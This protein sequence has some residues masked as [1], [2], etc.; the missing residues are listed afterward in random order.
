MQGNTPYRNF[1][2]GEG[3]GIVHPGSTS[4]TNSKA[5][6]QNGLNAKPFGPD[7]VMVAPERITG[8]SQAKV[9]DVGLQAKWLH[10]LQPVFSPCCV[11]LLC[12]GR[13]HD[14]DA[15]DIGRTDVLRS[16][17]IARHAKMKLKVQATDSSPKPRTFPL[18]APSSAIKALSQRSAPLALRL[19]A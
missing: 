14:V 4:C 2:A 9:H 11:A 18:T 6:P 7:S 10:L 3:G 13:D 19:R 12:K 5:P 1:H 16:L 15:D 8:Q 17:F